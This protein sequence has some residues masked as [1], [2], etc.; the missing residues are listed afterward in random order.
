MK[1]VY[2]AEMAWHILAIYQESIIEKIRSISR[3]LF[4]IYQRK[5]FIAP[6]VM[7]GP[8]VICAARALSRLRH[9]SLSWEKRLF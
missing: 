9:G 8:Q 2:T 7:R 5:V 3:L 6:Y 4:L 1:Y